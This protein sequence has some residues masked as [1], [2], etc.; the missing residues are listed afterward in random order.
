VF[1]RK[2]VS[3]QSTQRLSLK[4]VIARYEPYQM[5]G[6]I[7]NWFAQ[8]KNNPK[9]FT[10]VNLDDPFFQRRE[11]RFVIDNEAYDIFEEMVNYATVQVK[12][13]RKGQRPFIEELTID[14]Q[15][16][17]ENGQTASVSFARM[18]DDAQSFSYATQWS[19]RGGHLYPAQ[20][21]WKEGELTVTLAAPVKPVDIEAET[22]LAELERMGFS[23]ISVE[24]RYKRFGK[25][26]HDKKGLVLSPA[27]GEAIASKTVYQDKSADKIAYRLIYHHKKLGQLEDTEW[28]EL[29]GNYLYCLPSDPISSQVGEWLKSLA[30]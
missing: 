6:N 30:E 1:K 11:V 18:G 12:V 15:Y 20:P 25:E 21:Q 16:L 24:L 2:S 7:G 17:Q 8:H 9:L 10:E 19:L 26:Y 4:K 28:R 13:E 29:N 14:K 3:R 5:V 22:D 23:R 27:T